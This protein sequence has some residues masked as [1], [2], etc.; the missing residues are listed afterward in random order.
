[1]S[2]CPSV[3]QLSF[4][5]TDFHESA[6]LFLEWEMFQAE[7]VEKI[8][9]H[10]LCSSVTFFWKLCH[11]WDK[12]EKYRRARQA[13]DD[14]IIWHKRFMRVLS[15]S[16]ARARSLTHEHT[17]THACAHAPHFSVATGLGIASQYYIYLNANCEWVFFSFTYKGFTFNG[18]LFYPY[19]HYRYIKYNLWVSVCPVI[20]FSLIR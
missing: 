9:T 7:V 15:F 16:H 12:I 20:K 4:H 13:T 1:M 11:L 18:T 10:I 19:I 8:E 3:E 6:E 17:R 5:W 14:N 2:V